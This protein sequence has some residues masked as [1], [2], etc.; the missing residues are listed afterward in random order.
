MGKLKDMLAGERIIEAKG[1]TL[2]PH[3]TG[4][5]PEREI[6]YD[7][8]LKQGAQAEEWL[9]NE[10]P[11]LKAEWKARKAAEHAEKAA[12]KAVVRAE[13]EAQRAAREEGRRSPTGGRLERGLPLAHIA[14][15]TIKKLEVPKEGSLIQWDSEIKRF[16]VR[17]AAV[18]AVTFILEYRFNG[19]QRRYTIG[20]YPEWTAT[21]ARD[22]ALELK[23]K[24][25][26]GIDPL[27]E[28]HK[29]NTEPTLDYLAKDYLERYAQ[30]HKRPSSVRDDRRMLDK[31]ILPKLGKMR[32]T[33]VVTRDIEKLHTSLKATPYQANRVKALLSKMFNLAMKWKLRPDNPAREIPTF[34]EDQRESFLTI[35]QMQKLREAIERYPDASARN[36]LLLLMLT[37]S[38]EAEV[39]KA[40]WEQFDLQRGVWT[41]PSH[42]TKQKKTEHVPLSPETRKLL[43]SMA[44][45]HLS[46]PLFP[47]TKGKGKDG[48]VTGSDRRVSLKRP[49]VQVCRAAGQVE[50]IK[51][52]GK[53]RTI[54]RYKPTL[55]IHDLRHNFA[56]HLAN[57]GVSLQVV[58]GLIG[59]TQIRTTQRYSH[60]QD[61]ALR[62][63]TNLFGSIYAAAGKQK[64]G[65]RQ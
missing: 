64:T 52:K 36:A 18:G 48:K 56:S 3:G 2:A 9:K 37:G 21:A 40:T 25:R 29:H 60:L 4:L 44:P 17:I 30:A 10:A 54:T 14:E 26:N 61:A 53:R 20:R 35:E 8:F 6:R 19:T 1:E 15:K 41:K 59:H 33:A 63:A 13:R 50:V 27:E 43:D 12:Q 34:H 24:I 7:Q 11:K 62:D 23:K 45:E 58:G 32:I 51:G 46:G 38:R 57:K 55:R 39:L 49:W 22:E 16:G 42:H 28:R 5:P 47:G 65:T 31:I